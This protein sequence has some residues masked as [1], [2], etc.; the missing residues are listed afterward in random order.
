M[1]DNIQR[2]LKL[3]SIVEQIADSE[4][5]SQEQHLAQQNLKNIVAEGLLAIEEFSTNL[6]RVEY[7]RNLY[8]KLLNNVAPKEL[9]KLYHQVITLDNE[10]LSSG[11]NC[12]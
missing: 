10:Q 4:H 6:Q 8:Y 12:N 2:L 1:K 5:F 3:V 7:E 9:D 11:S